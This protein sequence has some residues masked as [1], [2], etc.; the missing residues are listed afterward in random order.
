M[1]SDLD[2]AFS[3]SV[4]ELSL[5]TVKNSLR[6]FYSDAV[7]SHDAIHEFLLLAPAMYP[8]RV[9]RSP[10]WHAKSA[11]LTYHWDTFDLA[12]SS[13]YETLMGNYS[14]GFILL[15]ATLELLIRGAFFECL[16]HRKFR[17]RSLILDEDRRG[18]K[19]KHFLNDLFTRRPTIEQEFETASVS[20]YDRTS[21]LLGDPR[22]IPSN[23]TMLSQLA[24]WGIFKGIQAPVTTVSNI[25][26]KLSGDVHAHPNRTGTGRILIYQPRD[27]FESK[28][29]LRRVLSEYLRDL[30]KVADIGI[31]ITM[32]L[33]QENLERFPQTRDQIRTQFHQRFT[34]L[35]LTHSSAR[36]TTL[37]A[38][39]IE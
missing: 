17:E 18:K 5:D 27:L 29:V 13:Y 3:Y 34:D 25:Y 35:G 4:K 30:K 31:V 39:H 23:K 14:A 9:A 2:K 32:N 16:A 26:R 37:L 6:E 1:T 12:H 21:R 11:F 20:I 36:L 38:M 19:L 10:S 7:R 28:K 15:R 24:K 8:R 33:L 22:F